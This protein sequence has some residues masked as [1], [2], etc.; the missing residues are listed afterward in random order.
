MQTALVVEDDPSVRDLMCQRLREQGFGK[1]LTA[2]NGDEAARIAMA[3]PLDLVVLDY[4]LGDTSGIEV[5]E[6]LRA[7][8]GFQSRVLVTAAPTCLEAGEHPL[9]V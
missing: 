5:A 3:Q 4:R 7:L 6:R 8:P 9:A 2:A 1:L